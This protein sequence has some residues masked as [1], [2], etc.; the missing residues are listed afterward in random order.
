MHA[1]DGFHGRISCYLHLM[2]CP[3]WTV[4]AGTLWLLARCL[5]I[6]FYLVITAPF[7]K[8]QT[9]PDGPQAQA[10]PGPRLL[11]QH[12]TIV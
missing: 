6:Q 9:A 11:Q 2:V 5:Q 4:Y 12:T 8:T 1:V 3:L 7:C 10:L